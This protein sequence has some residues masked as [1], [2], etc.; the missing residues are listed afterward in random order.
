MDDD[1]I[2]FFTHLVGCIDWLSVVLPG[3]TPSEHFTTFFGVIGDRIDV[4]FPVVVSKCK[5]LLKGSLP[6]ETNRVKNWYTQ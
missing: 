1:N 2:K 5:K 3:M 6:K 4:L